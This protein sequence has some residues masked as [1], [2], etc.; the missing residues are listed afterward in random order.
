MK[1]NN[2]NRIITLTGSA[3]FVA[4]VTYLHFVQTDY[5][6]LE[7][8]MSELALGKQGFLMLWAFMYFALAV[9][10]AI[11]ILA[12]YQAHAVIK[13]LLGA[14]SL[15]LAGAGL[16]KLEAAS[17]LHITLVALAFIFLVFSMYLIPRL[18]TAFQTLPSTA[19]CWGLG[20]GTALFV[21]LGQG[22]LAIGLAQRLATACLLL[23]LG[24]LAL[25]SHTA[26]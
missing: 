9:A 12:T 1:I 26:Q 25:Q 23:W 5:N 17:T 13:L 4:I 11:R 18:V 3:G 10:G 20:A 16:F 19:I 2:I 21:G 24:W 6:P 15:S 14:A 22:V 8:L 7:Q